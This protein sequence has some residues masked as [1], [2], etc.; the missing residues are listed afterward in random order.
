[1]S[2][3]PKEYTDTLIGSSTGLSYFVVWSKYFFYVYDKK[4]RIIKAEKCPFPIIQIEIIENKSITMYGI[5]LEMITR[6]EDCRDDEEK[7]R[8][9]LILEYRLIVDHY[10]VPKKPKDPKDP[11]EADVLKAYVASCNRIEIH[12]C[13]ILTRDKKKLF[14]CTEIAD[15]VIECFR[16]RPEKVS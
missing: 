4:G 16:N 10:K 12:S 15:N 2:A 11:T 6:G 14:A 13:L 9:Y 5:E 7:E 8:E 1:M 3:I